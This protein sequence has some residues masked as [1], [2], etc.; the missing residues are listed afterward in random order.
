M[1]LALSKKRYTEKQ[2]TDAVKAS[3][4]F[5]GNTALIAASVGIPEITVT[6][7]KRTEWWKDAVNEIKQ[8][9]KLVLSARLKNVMEKSWGVVEDRMEHGDFVLNNKTGE[10]VRKPVYL[11]DAAKVAADTVL[12]REK[13]ERSEAYT[14]HADQVEDKLAKLA[15]AFSDLSKGIKPPGETTV[16]GKSVL[17]LL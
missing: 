9:E 8:E 5:G 15:K 2:K 4:V 10:V 16:H 6:T 17:S 12:I 11:R 3:F 13:L 7:W 1:K 14:V